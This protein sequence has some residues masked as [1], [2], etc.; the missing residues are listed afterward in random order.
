MHTLVDITAHSTIITNRTAQHQIQ[1]LQVAIESLPA[2]QYISP[3]RELQVHF[4]YTY[5][6]CAWANVTIVPINNEQLALSV[7][8]DTAELAS[9]G[10]SDRG[11][12]RNGS[13]QPRRPVQTHLE[14]F[15][16]HESD[17]EL[18]TNRDNELSRQNT[19]EEVPEPISPEDNSPA[20][21]RP[22]TSAL[23][24]MLRRSPPSTSQSSQD[25]LRPNHTPIIKGLDGGL[26][27]ENLAIKPDRAQDD[28]RTPL[29]QRFLE[30]GVLG[31]IP[32]VPDLERQ[33]ITR[34]YRTRL[35]DA[36][37]IPLKTRIKGAW[38]VLNP[39]RWEKEVIW[40]NAV[41]AP[42]GYLP[43]VILGL[44]LNI[45][46]ALSYGMFFADSSRP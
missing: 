19:I 20:D 2:L 41:V 23:T 4:S 15:F 31:Q 38:T 43:A 28:E 27:G 16:P 42:V 22:G 14:S 40:Q 18:S 45:L 25:Q 37:Q 26:D 46:D 39:K 35:Q 17:N 21:G 8:E 9:Y 12:V 30:P 7:R 5:M 34:T 10:L 32:A 44:L 24:D 13:P 29:L 1:S 36:I 6:K 33:Q 3:I 11:S